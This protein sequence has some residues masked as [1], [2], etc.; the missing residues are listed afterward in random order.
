MDLICLSCKRAWPREGHPWRCVCGGR[1]DIPWKSEFPRVEI[2][3]RPATL[4]RYREALPLERPDNGVSLGEGMTPLVPFDLPGGP[5]LLKCDHLQP[6]GSYKDRGAAVMLSAVREMGVTEILE[7]SSGNAGASIAAYAARAGVRAH[8]YAPEAAS[9]GK[10][11][12]IAAAGAV[13]H[14]IPG[15]RANAAAAALAAAE[16]AYYASHC[17]NPF[18][19]HGVK[20][21]AFEIVEQLGWR[22]PEEVVVP[23]GNGALLLGLWLGFDELRLAGVIRRWPKFVAVQAEACAP[24]FHSWRGTEMPDVRPTVA[25][26]I[27]IAAP[28][29]LREIRSI[30]TTSGGR[31]ETV[32]EVEI[33]AALRSLV[34][35]GFFVEPTAAVA[36]AACQRGPVAPGTVVLLTGHGLK[37]AAQV[38]ALTGD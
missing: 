11:A 21:A 37:A 36:F 25:E 27:A 8:I 38:A 28:V 16:T 35:Q 32:N 31:V 29:R 34:R 26:G 22:V 6:S 20:T 10:L 1:L 7:D 5:L 30:V 33:G 4:W 14:P 23:V 2:E 9:P 3:H 12:Q 19:L 17:W 13:L 24:V 15:P 18:F